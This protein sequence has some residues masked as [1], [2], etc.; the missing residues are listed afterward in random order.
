MAMQMPRPFPL[1]G[2]A[3]AV[4]AT[5]LLTTGAVPQPA[6]IPPAVRQAADRIESAQLARDLEYLASDALRGRNT[7]SP[8]FDSAAVYIARRLRRAGLKPLGD[9]GGFFQHYELREERIDTAD[10]FIEIGGQQFR[11][12]DGF[13]IGSFAGPVSGDLGAVFVGHGWTV[14]DKGVD[15]WAGIDA[16]GKLVIVSGRNPPATLGV[17]R[18][19]R[20]TPN[21]TSPMQEA[22]RRGAVA[23]LY[24][25]PG[26][27]PPANWDRARR[28]NLTRLE[29]FPIVPSAYAAP[30]MSSVVLAR[31]AAEALLAGERIAAG[32]DTALQPAGV[33]LA[34]RVR[35]ELPL[36]VRQV[37]SPYNVVGMI[38]GS[39]PVLRNEY[40][41]IESHLDGAVGSVA[42]NGDSIYNS[43]DDNASGSAG[44]LAIAEQMMRAPRP[45][46]SLIFIWDSGEERGLWGTRQF[47][48]RPPVP[49]D[50]IVAHFN[51]DMIGASR[52][53]GSAD[54]ASPEVTGPDEVYIH[55]PGVLSP[56]VDSLLARVNRAYLN[57]TYNRAYD[58]PDNQFFYPRTDAGPFLERGV[59]TINYFTGLHPRYHGPA[60]EA[61]YLDPEKME[62]VARTV[63][64]S[65][66]MVADSPVRP[67]I[68]KEIPPSVPRYGTVTPRS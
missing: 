13:V 66:W 38:E 15:P 34:K 65:V 61:R 47:V 23:I 64:A 40:V 16:R 68:E 31:P 46:R 45:K 62:R 42:Q 50:Q 33:T 17:R 51:I 54:S 57:L 29:L 25:E 22:E 3:A 1:T 49:L 48:H 55:G 11:F 30:P 27:L 14:P 67:R 32:A 63:F 5:V 58:R 12:G 7:P 56:T 6:G 20:V 26:V 18:I 21:A 60:D 2:L 59:L 28:L 19:G 9:S 35:I 10:A 4:I 41:T 39:D 52:A 53:P 8:G 24:V 36:S 37:H 43:A 44:T